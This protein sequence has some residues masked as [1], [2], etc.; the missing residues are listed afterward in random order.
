MLYSF[1]KAK[2]KVK[3]KRLEDHSDGGYLVPEQC[4]KHAEAIV[5]FGLSD[6][7]SFEKI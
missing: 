3:L 4:A 7:W 2:Y 1:F 6:N 5:I